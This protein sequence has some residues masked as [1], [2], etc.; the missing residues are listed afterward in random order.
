MLVIKVV[1]LKNILKD[2]YEYIAT[3]AR[4]VFEVML[5][6]FSEIARAD[7]TSKEDL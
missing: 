4:N 2:G 5:S 1:M 6:L 7:F 3:T